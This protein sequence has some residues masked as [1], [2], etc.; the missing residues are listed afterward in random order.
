MDLCSLLIQH[1]LRGGVQEIRRE[2]KEER[3]LLEARK[4]SDGRGRRW[5][6]KIK[7]EKLRDSNDIHCLALPCTF[8]WCPSPQQRTCFPDPPLL[9]SV[10]CSGNRQVT[11][12]FTQ[13]PHHSLQN[14]VICL[15]SLEWA[16]LGLVVPWSRPLNC[17]GGYGPQAGKERE[18]KNWTISFLPPGGNQP[19]CWLLSVL[20][21]PTPTWM[22]APGLQALWQHKTRR[23]IC[24]CVCVWHR[25]AAQM[26]GAEWHPG[27][28]PAQWLHAE[29]QCFP[30]SRTCLL[31]EK[32]LRCGHTDIRPLILL[33]PRARTPMKSVNA[34]CVL[35]SLCWVGTSPRSWNSGSLPITGHFHLTFPGF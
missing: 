7:K 32:I 30:F 1:T 5:S 11:S 22:I 4:R 28:F 25:S 23:F 8:G 9:Q 14:Q 15:S 31:T 17:V 13:L 3:A 19:G 21:C 35:F 12:L 6:W 33:N 27:S 2:G 26:Q 34:H 29:G 24:F 18:K 16:P 20:L 10:L